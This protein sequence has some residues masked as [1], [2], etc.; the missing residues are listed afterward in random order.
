MIH[1]FLDGNGR[2]CR[3]IMNVVLMKYTG[4][5]VGMGGTEEERMEYLAICRRA[6]EEIG[7]AGELAGV[8]LG[9]V[10]EEM[11]RMNKWIDMGS[12]ALM[13]LKS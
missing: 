6:G 12:R 8:V 13:D 9:K 1:P 5:V 10:E 2:M 4:C 7:G 11:D 3:L